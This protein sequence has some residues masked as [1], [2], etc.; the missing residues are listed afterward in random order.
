MHF[1]NYVTFNLWSYLLFMESISLTIHNVI[2]QYL[3]DDKVVAN[4]SIEYY[5]AYT[6]K[7]N[8]TIMF[9]PG[10]SFLVALG[11]IFYRLSG[12]LIT[13]DKPVPIWLQAIISV[14]AISNFLSEMTSM[15]YFDQTSDN[16]NLFQKYGKTVEVL[17]GAELFVIYI[18]VLLGRNHVSAIYKTVLDLRKFVNDKHRLNNT[19]LKVLEVCIISFCILVIIIDI[20]T[21]NGKDFI[22]DFG[23]A[24]IAKVVLGIP[25]DLLYWGVLYHSI[26]VRFIE[27]KS[28][29]YI[30][31][32]DKLKMNPQKNQISDLTVSYCRS[33]SVP[34]RESSTNS[35][36][37]DRCSNIHNIHIQN[38][39]TLMCEEL[40]S[41]PE[42]EV[43]S[44]IELQNVYSENKQ[45]NSIID[46]ESCST[47]HCVRST[48]DIQPQTTQYTTQHQGSTKNTEN[49]TLR[50][51]M[52]PCC[53][54]TYITSSVST[55]KFRSEIQEHSDLKNDC[56]VYS[57]VQSVRLKHNQVSVCAESMTIIFSASYLCDLLYKICTFINEEGMTIS[58]TSQ[59]FIFSL[60]MFILIVITFGDDFIEFQRKA[61]CTK[62]VRHLL[63]NKDNKTNKNTFHCDKSSL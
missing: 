61:L 30:S 23:I 28:I 7:K 48:S 38:S 8:E 2:R 32:E 25:L 35:Q 43:V 20:Y 49:N 39:Q 1:Q 46:I 40:E 24:L 26:L 60:I 29:C 56:K 62:A 15:Y 31:L 50:I 17:W 12:I 59:I 6:I 57:M 44:Y 58:T 18:S 36:Q 9:H 52:E 34:S 37:V 5:H 42:E 10:E 54:N 22:K 16:D 3:Q 33:S 13:T 14:F 11:A 55:E 4:F 53:S 27:Y 21:Y 19:W 47:R 51:E 41:G 45:L 63:V